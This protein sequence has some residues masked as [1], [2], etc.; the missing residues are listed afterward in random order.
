MTN[1]L[2]QQARDLLAA[3]FRAVH[4][5]VPPDV[6]GVSYEVAIRAIK[7]ALNTRTSE[8]WQDIESA[9]RDG[10]EIIVGRIVGIRLDWWHKAWWPTNQTG[11]MWRTANGACQPTHWMPLPT[12]PQPKGNSNG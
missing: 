2:E 6:V 12:P 11:T 8:H 4:G 9:P 5:A 1:N 7:A 3:E 10:T